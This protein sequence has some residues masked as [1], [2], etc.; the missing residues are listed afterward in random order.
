MRRGRDKIRIR[1]TYVLR[2]PTIF[3]A[4]VALLLLQ[5]VFLLSKSERVDKG[6]NNVPTTQLRFPIV[7]PPDVLSPGFLPVERSREFRV[8]FLVS[9]FYSRRPR[10]TGCQCPQKTEI[11]PAVFTRFITYR[12]NAEWLPVLRK[13]VPLISVVRRSL[14]DRITTRPIAVPPRER[15]KE[16]S[17][18]FLLASRVVSV[19]SRKHIYIYIYIRVYYY[20]IIIIAPSKPELRRYT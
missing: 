2:N 19:L 18:L 8:S 3:R 10:T 9:F 15:E 13:L 6:K 5:I 1:D 17:S 12:V 11:P 7:N 20:Y 4:R 16:R 14:T